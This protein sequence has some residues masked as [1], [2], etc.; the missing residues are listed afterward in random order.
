MGHLGEKL[1]LS[2]DK[3]LEG[4]VD[5]A[6]HFAPHEFWFW[7]QKLSTLGYKA[8]DMARELYEKGINICLT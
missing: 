6:M 7:D 5:P 3:M 8:E 4:F 1:N 2:Y